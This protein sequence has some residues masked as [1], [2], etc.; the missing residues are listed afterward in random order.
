MLCFLNQS[1]YDENSIWIF[2]FLFW[3]FCVFFSLGWS[4]WIYIFLAENREGFF[5]FGF[6][7]EIRKFSDGW[8]PK[9][10]HF[11][12]NKWGVS[13]ESGYLVKKPARQLDFTGGSD[14]MLLTQILKVS[15]VTVRTDAAWNCKSSHSSLRFTQAIACSDFSLYLLSFL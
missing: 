1:S 9:R 15:S 11:S 12:P 3:V 5:F 4:V 10:K 8:R 6:L 7:I 14:E 2:L 13:D